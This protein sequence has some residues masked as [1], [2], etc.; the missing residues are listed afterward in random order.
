MADGNIVAA[1]TRL[2][3]A[4]RRLTQ[5]RAGVYHDRTLYA[6]SLYSCLLDDVAGTQG[7]TRTPAKSLPPI[8]IDAS[9]LRFD[10]DSQSVKWLPV[11][12]TTPER[13]QLLSAKTFRPQDFDLVNKIAGKVDTW[14]ESIINLIIDP[15]ARK[16]ISAP[17][18][19]C[20]Q[21]R[22]YRRDSGGDT[23]RE[24][25][26]KWTANVGFECAACK[27]H[28][29]PEQTL[30]FSKLLGFELPEGVLE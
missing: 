14:C 3:H 29:A 30:F 20:G 5:P 26:L 18:P 9:Q 11:P 6:P 10:I 25:A 12:G 23:V 19:A 28:W 8:W 13:L 22:V 21:E 16:Y 27:A 17:C 15:K 1:R 2:G 7:D 4:V 24:P